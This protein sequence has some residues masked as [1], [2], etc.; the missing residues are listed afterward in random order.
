MR[1]YSI[2]LMFLI[3]VMACNNAGPYPEELPGLYRFFGSANWRLVGDRD[4]S[5]IYFSN[6]PDHSYKTYEFTME[7]GDSILRR[8]GRIT[9]DK[10]HIIWELSGNRL[11]LIRLTASGTE[12][13]DSLNA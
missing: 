13:K 3:P 5:Y 6:Q 11:S 8:Q 1:K 10:N 2:L 4:T 12:W 9:R 7:K